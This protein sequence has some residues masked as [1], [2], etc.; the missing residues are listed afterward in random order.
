MVSSGLVQAVIENASSSDC[1]P[2]TR[3]AKSSVSYPSL[4]LSTNDKNAYGAVVRF[5][6]L[7]AKIFPKAFSPILTKAGSRVVLSK[8]TFLRVIAVSP[9]CC[10]FVV[11]LDFD[12]IHT[13]IDATPAAERCG[14]VEDRVPK[15]GIFL[16]LVVLYLNVAR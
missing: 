8:F 16:N 9:S 15:L 3:I 2:V 10:W 7:V 1:M 11:S 4:S 12:W 14:F 6:R 5:P 13:A